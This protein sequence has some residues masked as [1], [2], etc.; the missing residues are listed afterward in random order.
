MTLTRFLPGRARRLPAVVAAAVAGAAPCAPALGQTYTYVMALSADRTP[1]EYRE[2]L[3]VVLEESRR[4]SRLV[5]DLLNL[6]RADA[7]R[8]RL[9]HLDGAGRVVELEGDHGV[10]S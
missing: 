4:L 3:S 5:E 9:L 10:S 2:S 7:G 6:A 8:V 1:E